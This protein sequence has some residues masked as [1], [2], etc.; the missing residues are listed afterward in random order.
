MTPPLEVP[1]DLLDE[2]NP[3]H[4]TISA[5]LPH[6]EGDQGI[7]QE[8]Q[9]DQRSPRLEEATAPQVHANQESLQVQTKLQ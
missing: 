6:F 1:M 4:M 8:E 5:E 2:I 3:E 9:V 7:H